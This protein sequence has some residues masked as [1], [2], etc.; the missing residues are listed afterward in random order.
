M[1]KQ[2]ARRFTSTTRSV[3]S[4]G[5][6][7]K[8]GATGRVQRSRIEAPEVTPSR[9][10]C[11]LNS[12]RL[13]ACITRSQVSTSWAHLA[14]YHPRMKRDD[15]GTIEEDSSYGQRSNRHAACWL[16]QIRATSYKQQKGNKDRKAIR[17]QQQPQ[18]ASGRIRNLRFDHH[19]A[20]YNFPG[21][22]LMRARAITA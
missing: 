21:H 1:N 5:P 11:N 22:A 2:P 18:M 15:P 6:S 17:P 16:L 19:K 4:K 12:I 9:R 3:F 7:S 14:G 10:L 8:S 13:P 20:K